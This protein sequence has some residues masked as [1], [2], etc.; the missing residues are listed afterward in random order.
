MARKKSYDR[1]E[2]VNA[3]MLAFWAKGFGSLGV[4]EIEQQ[5]GINRFA[6]QTEF[7]GKQGL[8]LEALEAYLELSRQ[9]VL[10]ALKRGSLSG[11]KE[12]LDT[13]VTPVE[14]DPR[15]LG[16]LMVNT[17]IEN[18]DLEITDV[19]ELVDRH[20]ENMHALF[21]DALLEARKAGALP[22]DFDVA[23]A[24]RTLLTF[25]I[26]LEVYV[27]MHKDMRAA[28]EQVAFMKKQI[29]GWRCDGA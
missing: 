19:Q 17:A 16:C 2:A 29:D 11:I 6:L 10:R 18:A 5:T 3:A 12:F 23:G 28:R 24:A 1:Q 14:N 27:R 26:G 9:S 20:Y 22:V 7:G 4:R 13:L 21:E 8:F 25:S 15:N